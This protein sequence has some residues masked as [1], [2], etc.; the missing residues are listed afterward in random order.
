MDFNSLRSSVI[1]SYGRKP[2]GILKGNFLWNGDYTQCVSIDGPAL[3]GKYC[4]INTYVNAFD[5]IPYPFVSYLGKKKKLIV[6]LR[7]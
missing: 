3:K 5:V 4:Y 1:D 6:E 7:L 2:S